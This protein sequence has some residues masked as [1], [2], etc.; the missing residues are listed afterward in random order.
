MLIIHSCML[1]LV[2]FARPYLD[3]RPNM[4]ALAISFANVFNYCLVLTAATQIQSP[5][6]L[7]YMLIVV[8]IV[9]PLLSLLFGWYLNGRHSSAR[10]EKL[11]MA[12]QRRQYIPFPQVQK[13]RKAVERHINEFTLRVLA[14]WTWGVLIASVVAGELI[15]IG[16]F[17][18]AALTPVSGHTASSEGRLSD[19]A[20]C[21]REEHA[22]TQ[23]FL[24]FGNW[25]AFTQSCCC[26]SRSNATDPYE[27]NAHITELWSCDNSRQAQISSIG[28]LQR[29][30][31]YKER[32][33]RPLEP[34][35]SVSPVRHFCDTVFRDQYGQPMAQE[36]S[37][38]TVAGKL[39]IYWYSPDG[40][41][42]QFHDDF[43]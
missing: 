10:E 15:F 22:R 11:R 34:G 27:L 30:I 31:V 38:D 4:L 17:A 43:W 9:L 26:M 37:F 20:E 18:E 19:V 5:S 33:R 41:V 12:T 7:I 8:N 2:F 16:T 6:W 13:K 21:Y 40:S 32:Q 23:E 36:P 14:S 39:G 1:L 3:N 42:L 28:R 35:T 24:G 29:P 25:S